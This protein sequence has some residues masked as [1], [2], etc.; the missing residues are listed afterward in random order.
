MIVNIMIQFD[1]NTG[2][3]SVFYL[4]KCIDKRLAKMPLSWRYICVHKVMTVALAVCEM[5]F[6][7]Y[8]G[9]HY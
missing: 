4:H 6:Q 8:E 7:K 9:T 5:I 1:F 3:I 2:T